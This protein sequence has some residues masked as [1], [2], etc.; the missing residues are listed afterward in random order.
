MPLS[1]GTRLG[2]YEVLSGLGEGGM[3]EVYRARD[4]RLQ[5]DVAIKVLPEAFATDEARLSRFEQ[6]ALATAALNHPNI[7]VVFDIGREGR[8]AYV[9]AELLEGHTL[10]EVIE[11]GRLP[12]RK[13]VDYASQIASGLAAAHA[14]GIVHRDLKPENVFVTTE[15]RVK[16]LD[17]GLAKWSPGSSDP[18]AP[19]G[20]E[21]PASMA[22]ETHLART[23]PG[24]VVGTIGYMAPEQVRGQ[25]VDHRADIFSFGAVLY[26]MLAG[27]RAFRGDTAADTMTAI[28]KEG[29]ADISDSGVAV[30]SS[31]ARVVDRCLEKAPTSRFQS[32]SD[33]AFALQALGSDARSASSISAA[34]AD[35]PKARQQRPWMLVAGAALLAGAL[36]GA[37]AWSLWPAAALPPALEVD[38]AAPPGHVTEVTSALSPDGSR[39]ALTATDAAGRTQLWLRTFESGATTPVAGTDEANNPFWSPDGAQIGFFA[40]GRLK[41]VTVANGRVRVICDAPGGRTAGT[42]NAQDVIVFSTES[43]LPLRRVD[44]RGGAAPADLKTFGFRPHFLPDGRYY[45]FSGR[46]AAA[47]GGVQVADLESEAV[48]PLGNGRDATYADGHLL[49]VRGTSLLA[50]PFDPAKRTL[51]GEPVVVAEVGPYAAS[52]GP[53]YTVA[54]S[55]VAFRRAADL[56]RH[57]VWYSRDGARLGE[58]PGEGIWR[59]PSLSPNDAHV[60]VERDEQQGTGRDIWIVDV[61]RRTPRVLSSDVGGEMTPAWSREGDRVIFHSGVFGTGS[62]SIVAKA[63]AGGAVETLIANARGTFMDLMPDGRSALMFNLVEGNR[64]ILIRP[65]DA[66]APPVVFARSTFNEAQPALSPDGRWLAYVSDELGINERRDVY[67]QA[68]PGGG[69]K[70]HVTEE[71]GGGV[72]PR[73]RR[74]GQEL[75]Y[76]APEGRIVAVPVEL[77]GDTA[78]FGQARALFQSAIGFEGGLGNRAHYD[79]TRDGQRFIVAEFTAGR[80]A[81][82]APFTLLVN[83]RSAV[84]RGVRPVD[85]AAGR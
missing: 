75:F 80:A 69:K 8:T 16:I 51:G 63:L 35:L 61:A 44:A 49:Y 14:K 23:E 84:A 17:F 78:R 6:E 82:N 76:V 40:G 19:A 20:S 68:F 50:Q 22:A 28:L 4:A 79:V 65:L 7:L 72:Q 43:G 10:R 74:D 3:G 47:A 39:F 25:A 60:A 13:A 42:W 34:P 71:T 11:A 83:W 58:I 21:D 59:N 15:E 55:L 52:T 70:V 27:R 5:R 18:G 31:L 2:S 29:P 56:S 26:E 46:E 24:M 66:N 1:P 48:V 54:G 57:L 85:A 37:V 32:A 12:L 45:L 64:D 38:V 53:N 30:P 73:W 36:T 81:A 67:I 62:A 33:L 77:S 41:A 9:V